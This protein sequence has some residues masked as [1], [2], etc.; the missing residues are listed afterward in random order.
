MGTQQFAACITKFRPWVPRCRY[1]L[2][3]CSVELSEGAVCKEDVSSDL[4]RRHLLHRCDGGAAEVAAAGR[5]HE[6][7]V[8]GHLRRIILPS[9]A[10]RRT[11]DHTFG[12]V[13]SSPIGAAGLPLQGLSHLGIFRAPPLCGGPPTPSQG[14]LAPPPFTLSDGDEFSMNRVGVVRNSDRLIVGLAIVPRSLYRH[15]LR[16]P[17]QGDD[18]GG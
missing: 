5:D 10:C 18:P 12:A 7:F 16:H 3:T 13:R 11:G 14:E 1:F 15:N 6:L 9:T 8:R 17:A 2:I 4:A